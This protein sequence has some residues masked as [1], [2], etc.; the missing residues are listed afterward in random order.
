MP[1]GWLIFVVL[2]QLPNGLIIRLWVMVET[3]QLAR[4]SIWVSW[5]RLTPG[6]LNEY[7]VT[8]AGTVMVTGR[9]TIPA[10]EAE[11]SR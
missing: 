7:W 9:V 6:T 11:S 3:A 2:L 10:G 1:R 4:R 8:P 5:E